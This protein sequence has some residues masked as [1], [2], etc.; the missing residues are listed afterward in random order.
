M[1]R[2]ATWT[3][4]D[5][6]SVGFGPLDSV[7]QNSATVRT[8]G[9]IEVQQ[10]VVEFDNLPTDAV[11]AVSSKAVAIP[12]RSVIQRATLTVTEAWVG[13]TNID[14]GLMDVDG[15]D[16]DDDGLD[17]AVLVSVMNVI[18][19]VVQM[20]GALVGGILDIGSADGYLVTVTT[21]T[22]TAGKAILMIEYVRPMPDSDGRAVLTGVQTGR[23]AS[24][25]V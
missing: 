2:E 16:I 8:Q 18:G 1:S 10:Y 14:F 22:Y 3:N 24:L 5:G 6:L 7:N 13:G 17:V 9:N 23:N 21:G 15:T 4:S 11:S 20:N 25:T 19:D 12:A